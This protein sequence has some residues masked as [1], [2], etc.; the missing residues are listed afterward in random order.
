M[1]WGRLS[2]SITLLWFA[3]HAK[4]GREVKYFV[5]DGGAAYLRFARKGHILEGIRNRIWEKSRFMQNA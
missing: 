1:L 3:E 4:W 5:I 2:N